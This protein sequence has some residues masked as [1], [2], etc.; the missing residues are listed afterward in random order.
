M[1]DMYIIHSLIL[2]M[3]PSSTQICTIPTK[4]TVMLQPL[5][6]LSYNYRMS[7]TYSSDILYLAISRL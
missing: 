3:N 2:K 7:S 6:S 1:I 5:A 4:K